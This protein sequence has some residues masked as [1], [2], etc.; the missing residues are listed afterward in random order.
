MFQ[1]IDDISSNFSP[2]HNNSYL[3]R[4]SD[5]T[6]DLNPPHSIN[7]TT[8]ILVPAAGASPICDECE[9]KRDCGLFGI[10]PFD[11]LAYPS[12]Y[13]GHYFIDEIVQMVKPMPKR[14]QSVFH[15]YTLVFF[16]FIFLYQ[17]IFCNTVLFFT[18]CQF[19]KK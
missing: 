4:L 8:T 15:K 19:F 2:R 16:S 14:A 9:A 13:L 6:R 10:C 11:G 7:V 5:T 1:E 17:D 18:F 12:L 3:E